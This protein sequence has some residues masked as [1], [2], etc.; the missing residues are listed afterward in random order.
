MASGYRAA[1]Q[2]LSGDAP[3]SG[4][5][6]GGAGPVT[7]IF[8]GNDQ[9]AAGALRAAAD[10]GRRVPDDLSVAGYDDSEIAAYLV[11]ALTT[12]HQDLRGVARRCMDRLISAVR[13][14]ASLAPEVDLVAPAL[15][16]RASTGPVS[17][18]GPGTA[19]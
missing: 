19:S 18:G 17:P 1:V 6:A 3:G 15:V 11:P 10:L 14:E 7:A 5:G 13:G 8:A 16:V 2:L 4:G 12:V 9:M